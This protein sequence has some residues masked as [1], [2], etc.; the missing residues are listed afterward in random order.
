MIG[1]LRIRV[2]A[3]LVTSVSL[4]CLS[5]LVKISSPAVLSCS[6]GRLQMMNNNPK[7]KHLHSN[8]VKGTHKCKLTQIY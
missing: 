6:N 5:D 2:V 8:S 3:T 7:L 4:G 1:M